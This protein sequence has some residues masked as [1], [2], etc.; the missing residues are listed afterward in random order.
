MKNVSFISAMILMVAFAV[1]NQACKPKIELPTVMT[2]EITSPDQTSA[3]GGGEIIDDGGSPITSSGVCWSLFPNPTISDT[4]TTDRPVEKMFVSKLTNLQPNKTYYVR[5]YAVNSEGVGYGKQVTFNTLNILKAEVNISA[6]TNVTSG[7]IER[8]DG[9]IVKDGGSAITESGFVW[10]TKKDATIDKNKQI[11]IAS[12]TKFYAKIDN[13]IPDST[14]YV[15]AYAINGAGVSY[16]K[17]FYT[18]RILP[19]TS[20]IKIVSKDSISNTSAQI[21]VN[22]VGDNGNPITERGIHWA[23]A[24]DTLNTSNFVATGSGTGEYVSKIT[25]LEPDKKYYIKPYAKNKYGKV[26]GVKDSITTTNTAS[27]IIIMHK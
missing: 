20:S 25:N 1:I 2:H 26:Y 17:Y 24:P 23:L 12:G 10:D 18:V 22:I 16:S 13:L 9:E 7:T 27:P 8:I 6:P 14:Y 11:G 3:T 4:K 19:V 15:Y 21:K 5:A